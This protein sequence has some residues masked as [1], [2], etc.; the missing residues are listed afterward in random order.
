MPALFIN[1]PF[2]VFQD[3]DGQPLDNGYVY[4]GT[5][6]LDPQTNPVQV[7]FDDALTIPAAQ[8]LRTINGYV[9]NAGTPA[10]LYVNG[11]NFSIKVLDSKANLVYS[12][13]DGSGISP[14]ASGVQYDPAGV[15]AVATTVQAKLRETV[16]VKDFGAVGDGVTDDTAAIQAALVASRRVYAP[17]GTYKITNLRWLSGRTLYGDGCSATFIQ[18]GAANQYAINMLSNA[19][20]VGGETVGQ[21]LDPAL[22]DVGFIGAAAASVAC[23][24]ME[25]NGVFAI[26]KP[27]IRISV[28]DSYAAIR[29]E[30]ASANAIFFGEIWCES[31]NTTGTAFTT[32]GV[33][34]DWRLF[35]TGTMNGNAIH[36]VTDFDSRFSVISDGRQLYSGQNNEINAK[37]EAWAGTAV[38]EAIKVEGFNNRLINPVVINVP[39][40]KSPYAFGLFNTTTVIGMRVIGTFPGTC[41]QITAYLNLGSSGTIVDAVSAC[42]VKIEDSGATSKE[43]QQNWS[44]VGNCSSV[45]AVPTNRAAASYLRT[46]PVSGNTLTFTDGL[47]ALLVQPSALLATLTIVMPPNPI[48]G[49]VVRVGATQNGVTALTVNANAGQNILGAPTSLPANSGFAMIW[50]AG[51]SYWFRLH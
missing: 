32:G 7:Y 5:P 22:I 17:A 48:D 44:F 38:S 45:T 41:P 47:E 4:I 37:I 1:V 24:N 20:S 30:C 25:A 15:G 36:S 39:N 49:Q 40:A 2:P 31:N 26:F 8:P 50:Q 29:A 13:P 23:L 27:K 28:K 35:A 43:T 12:F 18:Q 21:I 34:N 11:V 10:Q 14:N 46:V 6:Y 42:P 33:Y 19:D 16:S 3:R 9:S 51:I